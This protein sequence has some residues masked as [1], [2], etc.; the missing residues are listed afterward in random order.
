MAVED[1]YQANEE[2]FVYVCKPNGTMVTVTNDKFKAD[3]AGV[4]TV[5]YY[6]FDKAGNA[7]TLH[8][9]ITVS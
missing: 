9:Q 2:V 3:K 8:Y 6:T 7:T 5:Y 4:Y 1:N